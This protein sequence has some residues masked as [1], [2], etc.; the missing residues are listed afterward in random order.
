MDYVFLFVLICIVVLLVLLFVK[1]T[2]QKE[3]LSEEKVQLIIKQNFMEI[4]SRLQETLDRTRKEVESSKDLLAKN[5][6]DTLQTVKNMGS[7]IEKLV[8]QQEEAERLGQSLRD[9]LQ[10]PKLR[11]DYGE[12]ILEELLE[13]TLPRGIW[14]RQYALNPE[15]QERVD[16]IVRF[17][18][19]IVPID[20]KF[21]RD[22]Y[23]RYLNA[24]D[25]A[26]KQTHWKNYVKNL[27]KKINSIQEK[28][29]RP[30][31]GTTEFALM[32]IPS[33]AIYYETIAEKNY[34]GHPCSLFE[35]AQ[36]RKVIPVSPNTFFAFLQVILAGIR[37]L[38]V[39][40]QARELQNALG[41][42]ERHFDLFY[43]QYESI[44]KE[45]QKA[46]KAYD[47]GDKHIRRFHESLKSVINLELPGNDKDADT[48][49]KLPT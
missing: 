31:L 44:G 38:E 34:L 45:V 49:T 48:I 41:K 20:S 36:Q 46:A 3:S 4:Q 42:L 23:N 39:I 13:Q 14:E 37:N 18:N 15:S 2:G 11:G 10:S 33:E 7:T 9:L 40:E 19:L 25:P 30:E 32:F 22:D 12:T 1:L 35:Y 28:Y 47:V 26:E 16:A 17:K 8:S 43:K 21:P 27:E 24:E 6:L 29:I 5:A